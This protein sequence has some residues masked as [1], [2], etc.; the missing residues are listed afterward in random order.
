M[1]RDLVTSGFLVV[2]ARCVLWQMTLDRRL[3]VET[4]L[5]A[6]ES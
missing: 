5:N 1:K 2:R 4:Q 3:N 6:T